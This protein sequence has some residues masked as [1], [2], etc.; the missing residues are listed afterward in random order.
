MLFNSLSFLFFF[1]IVTFLY[2]G[3]RHDYRWALLLTASAIF[4][5]AFV[6]VYILILIFLILVDYVAGIAIESAQGRKRRFYLLASIVAN[7]GVL[8]F[9]KYFN[10]FN[11]Y[12]PSAF[13]P[14]AYLFHL[15]LPIKN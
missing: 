4:Y 14:V 12:Y 1:P 9:F 2:F 6:P 11:T 5:M 13:A 3:L 10:F 7:V 15:S 8:A